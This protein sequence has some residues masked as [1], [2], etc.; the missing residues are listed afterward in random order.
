MIR[1]FLI[2]LFICLPA[3]AQQSVVEVDRKRYDQIA[4]V[5]DRDKDRLLRKSLKRVERL[6][7]L[8]GVPWDLGYTNYP[9]GE[10]RVYHFQGFYLELLCKV[11][12]PGA[13][14]TQR[15]EFGYTDE[16]E[17]M[18]NG[19]RWLALQNPFVRIDHETR[20]DVRMATYWKEMNAAL[21]ERYGGPLK[22]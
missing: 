1:A 8:D 15:R 2:S 13:S 17:F 6:L 7:R 19:V 18:R 4:R 9:L 5:I 3:L 10:C 20:R 14:P 21:A 12:P 11:L 22:K 16:K